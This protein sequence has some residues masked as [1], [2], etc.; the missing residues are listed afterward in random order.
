M[1]N[2]LGMAIMLTA[3]WLLLSGHY[4]GLLLTLGA[5]SI[6]IC[7][8]L[9]VRLGLIDGEG[10]PYGNIPALLLYWP[11]LV[12]QIVLSNIQ[13]VRACLRA[14]LDIHPTLVKV[15][16]GCQ[17]DLAKVTFA[18][19]ITLTPGTATI[20]VEGDK[21][22]VHALYEDAAQPEA[23]ADMDER[24]RRAIDGGKS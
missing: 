12:W 20:A 10:S 17:S 24:T 9:A 8:A 13:V 22:L 5:I 7:C 19:S 4:T 3:I 16:T 23:F 1:R 6:I 18:N 14:D 15:K 2:F 11:W 21:L